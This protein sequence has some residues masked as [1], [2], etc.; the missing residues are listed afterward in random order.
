MPKRFYKV[1]FTDGTER[2]AQLV[3]DTERYPQGK[4]TVETYS[5][6]FPYSETP[7][8]KRLCMTSP[9]N[10]FEEAFN[11]RSKAQDLF[12]GQKG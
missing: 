3:V 6:L 9:Y 2:T 7:K 11:E 1:W 8:M 10:S 12:L 5:R 4:A